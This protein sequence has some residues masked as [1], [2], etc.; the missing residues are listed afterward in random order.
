MLIPRTAR[1]SEVNVKVRAFGEPVPDRRGFVSGV[2]VRDDVNLQ[3]GG[4][5]GLD[6]VQEVT[7]LSGTVAAV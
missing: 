7:K 3:C 1:G 5:L 6:D 4:H 2:I